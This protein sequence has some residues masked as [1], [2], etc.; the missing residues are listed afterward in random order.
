MNKKIILSMILFFTAFI[1]FADEVFPIYFTNNAKL[2]IDGSNADWPLALPCIMESDTQVQ[3]EKRK[4]PESYGAKIWCFFDAKNFYIYG[5][6]T[7][8]T[9]LFNRHEGNEIYQGDCLEVY[10][11]FR[12]EKNAASLGK[13]DFQFGIG[14]H[15]E[16]EREQETWIWSKGKECVDQKISV[17]Q[18][19]TGYKMEAMIPLKNFGDN[20]SLKTGDTIWF[21]FAV[22]DGLQEGTRYT[23]MVWNGDDEDWKTPKLWKKAKLFDN[24]SKLKEPY[25][26]APPII[27]TKSYIRVYYYYNG[28]PYVGTVMVGNNKFKTDQDGGITLRE[29]SSGSKEF[30]FNYGSGTFKQTFDIG[31]KKEKIL[32]IL[33]VKE[34]KVNQLGYKI[35]EKK[36]FILTDNKGKMKNKQFTIVTPLDN[37][38]VFTGIIEGYKEDIATGD[39]N[40]Y[41]DFSD[42]KKK[43]RFRIHVDGIG[44]S[45][46]FRIEEDIFS[47]LFYTTMRSYYLQRC[48]IEI[49]DEKISKLKYGKCHTEDGF[50]LGPYL[51]G[52][53]KEALDV[54]GGWHDAGDYGKYIPTAGV[55]CVQLLLLYELTPGKFN[56]FKLDIPESDN[57]IPDILDEVKWELS[58]MLKMQDKSGGVYHK[59][60][61][62]IF[63]PTILPN[64]DT[65]IRLINPISTSSTAIFAATMAYA[66]KIYSKADPEFGELLKKAALNAGKFLLQTHTKKIYKVIRDSTGW[67]DTGGVSDELLWAFAELYR[68]TGDKKY[69]NAAELYIGDRFDLPIIGWENTYTLGLL[70]L[71]NCDKTPADLKKK[72]E[73]FLLEKSIALTEKIM[74]DGY[75]SSLA[76]AE[77]TWA[78]NKNLCAKGMFLIL[79]NQIFNRDDFEQAARYQL[80]YILGVNTLSKSFITMI[81]A[82]YVR[83]LHHRVIEAIDINIPGFLAGGPNNNAECGTYKK[84]QGPKGYRD[85]NKSFSCNEYAIDYNAPLVFL[86]GYFMKDKPGEMY[87]STDTVKS[88][89]F[90]IILIIIAGVLILLLAAFFIIKKIRK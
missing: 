63:P 85:Y 33:P 55:T 14:M 74:N 6:F 62:A 31:E 79:A 86:A 4:S 20:R 61:T 57:K 60:N 76:Q 64:E 84:G 18:T 15:R 27:A 39:K 56:K 9:P 3:L 89:N 47:E 28:K 52:G 2:K 43:G 11:G 78:S 81:G 58:W 82:D 69:F 46:A 51:N 36:S 23:Q 10:L 42:F 67:Y 48:G 53:K 54:T 37:K 16:D 40:Y 34:I 50:L 7:D 65:D 70:T 45:Y 38:V 26:L 83:Y 49:N 87:G 80:D 73:D 25:I 77:Y 32:V 35:N 88:N 19:K 5:E 1:N 21:D 22:D 59:V 13:N 75:R 66:Y 41:G 30:S 29:E 44:D 24:E 72:I 68:L 17:I 71:Y 90:F 8:K 12:E